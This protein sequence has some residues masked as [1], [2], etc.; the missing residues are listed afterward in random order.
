[1]TLLYPYCRTILVWVPKVLELNGETVA[2][3]SLRE[4]KEM[5]LTCT[6]LGSLPQPTHYCIKEDRGCPVHF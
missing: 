3:N 2:R 1:M 4:G 6:L 5:S